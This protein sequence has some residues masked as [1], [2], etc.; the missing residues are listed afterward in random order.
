MVHQVCVPQSNMNNDSICRWL[1]SLSPTLVFLEL[2]KSTHFAQIKKDGKMKKIRVI[3]SNCDHA[4]HGIPK[5]MVFQKLNCSY[6]NDFLHFTIIYPGK[7][8][9]APLLTSP[10]L[11]LAFTNKRGGAFLGGPINR[12][13]GIYLRI[14]VRH[15]HGARLLIDSFVFVFVPHR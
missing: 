4:S 11:L 12:L 14:L 6:L 8:V 15:A 9:T 5:S 10:P 1:C 7:Q 13:P 2:Q 3:R